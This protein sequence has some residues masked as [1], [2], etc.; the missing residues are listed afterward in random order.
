MEA[1]PLKPPP[2]RPSSPI[3]L[4]PPLKKRRKTVSFSTDEK[5]APRPPPASLPP[6]AHAPAPTPTQAL[7]LSPVRAQLP[8]SI[9][10]AKPLPVLLPFASKPGEA[11]SLSP[12][13]PARVL[14]VPPPVRSLR[15]DEPPKSPGPPAPPPA[16]PAAK[17]VFGKAPAL[18]PPAVCRTVHNLPLDHASMVRLSFEEPAPGPAPPAQR[19]RPRGRPRTASLSPAEEPEEPGAGLLQLASVALKLQPEAQDSEET[20]TSDEAEEMQQALER[21]QAAPAP[22]PSLSPEALQALQEHNYSRLP[23]APSLTP[24][25]AHR[26]AK[27]DAHPSTLPA[28][29]DLHAVSGVLEAP[30]EV[31]GEPP[32]AKEEPAELCP[33]LETV[34]GVGAL[35]GSGDAEALAPITTPPRKRGAGP[36]EVEEEEKGKMKGRKKKRKEKEQQQMKKQKERQ[37]RK[38]RKKQLEV[39]KDGLL[40]VSVRVAFGFTICV[41]FYS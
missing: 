25:P 33:P 12:S 7:L 28:H 37:S 3:L 4:L 2:P 18:S 29:I 38:Q 31:I 34:P 19:G 35:G 11:A 30:E 5:E 40:G 13:G 36:V 32:P 16:A 1:A 24:S 27:A 8:E 14:T 20:E 39:L 23:F 26:R 10:A 9:L 15:P 41:S 6:P 17:R 22:L 21:E